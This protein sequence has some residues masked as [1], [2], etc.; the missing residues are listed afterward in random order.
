MAQTGEGG[1]VRG[2]WGEKAAECSHPAALDLMSEKGYRQ[3]WL[4]EQFRDR[5]FFSRN[6]FWSQR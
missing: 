1:S 4:W 2:L 5:M 3:T 6:C